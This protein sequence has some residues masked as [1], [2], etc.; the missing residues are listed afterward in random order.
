[1]PDENDRH[2]RRQD[3][4]GHAQTLIGQGRC[5][6]AVA[7]LHESIRING[8]NYNASYLLGVAALQTRDVE[9][10]KTALLTC[11]R[12]KPEW[13]PAW[14]A[15]SVCYGLLGWIEEAV[16]AEQRA[17]LLN[18]GNFGANRSL[19]R[20]STL[21]RGLMDLRVHAGRLLRLDPSTP[22]NWRGLVVAEGCVAEKARPE[23]LRAAKVCILRAPD[24]F[25]ILTELSSAA[26]ALDMPDMAEWAARRAL[27]LAPNDDSVVSTLLAALAGDGGALITL[28]LDAIPRFSEP[29]AILNAL[30][31]SRQVPTATPREPAADRGRGFIPSRAFNIILDLAQDAVHQARFDDAAGILDLTRNVAPGNSRSARIER[32]LT[33]ARNGGT[34]A[35]TPPR[36]ADGTPF[37]L[38]DEHGTAETLFD[39]VTYHDVLAEIHDVLRPDVYLEIGLGKG[40]ALLLARSDCNAV[41]VDPEPLGHLFTEHPHITF[42]QGTSNTFFENPEHARR[43]GCGTID[44][45]FIDGM[46]LYEYVLRDFRNTERLM[47]L[48]GAIFLHD[49]LPPYAHWAGR[50]NIPGYPWAG[51]T[52]KFF[53]ILE[54]F[55]PDLDISILMAEPTGLGMVT[56]L[57]PSNTVLWERETEIL[58]CVR[59]DRFDF[60]VLWNGPGPGKIRLDPADLAGSIRPLVAAFAANRKPAT[61]GPFDPNGDLS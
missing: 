26:L 17:V 14:S 42:F 39:D 59:E 3:H 38:L 11:T 36:R 34:K 2:A 58:A 28:A 61:G 55:R 15:L 10:A 7:V 8:A 40:D 52:W 53:R 56:G 27:L 33:A 16:T 47:R 19:V 44:M 46:H 1:M 5:A 57:D 4:L 24:D 23:V 13:Q 51:D 45:A 25:P 41:G 21:R 29:T 31:S 32:I 22:E 9:T 49:L 37:R 54:R 48:D 30:L 50:D 60:D 43:L 18:P 12:A 6:E 35:A 20:L